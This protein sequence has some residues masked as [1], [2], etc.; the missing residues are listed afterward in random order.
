MM[1]KLNSL[2]GVFL[3]VTSIISGSG[4]VYFVLSAGQGVILSVESQTVSVEPDQVFTLSVHVDNV[5]NLYKWRLSISWD[6]AVMELEPAS[7]SAIAEGSFLQEAGR[8]IF[9]PNPYVAGSGYL[10]YIPC[11]LV[12]LTGSSGSGTLLTL[13]FKAIG[14]G[15]T[16]ITIS[17]SIL[18][19]HHTQKISHTLKEGHVSVRSANHDVGVSLE[20]PAQLVLSNS[21]LLNATVQNLGDVDETN[22][23][24]AILV[25]GV[26]KEERTDS[27]PI[28]GSYSMCFNW[29]PSY[30]GVYTIAA[31]ATPL[32]D[33]TKTD[34]NYFE[35]PVEVISLAIVPAPGK[36]I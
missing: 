23:N 20:A 21:V 24:L 28:G 12:Q 35:S 31:N 16:S 11:R 25:N 4:I 8:T 10:S 34:N 13:C 32:P 6:P 36:S 5:E 26:V 18:Y 19:N 29:T 22:V 17:N 15:E 1:K 14:D 7:I 3:L 30:K 27:L 33:E 9:Q 2:F